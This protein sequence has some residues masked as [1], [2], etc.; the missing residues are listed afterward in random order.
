MTVERLAEASLAAVVGGATTA[1]AVIQV[2]ESGGV[3]LVLSLGVSALVGYF[4][5]QMTV[6]VDIAALK[7][8]IHALRDELHRY[9]RTRIETD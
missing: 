3:I 2:E 7:A 9:Y 4:S 5:A 1:L 6:R 8:E